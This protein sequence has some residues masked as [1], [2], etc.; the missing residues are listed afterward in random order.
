[1]Y[2]EID[3]K[4]LKLCDTYYSSDSDGFFTDEWIYF[5][6]SILDALDVIFEVRKKAQASDL[7]ELN[8]CLCFRCTSTLAHLYRFFIEFVE[9]CEKPSFMKTI[10]EE[11]EALGKC[12][13]NRVLNALG[14]DCQTEKK[15]AET[16][17]L[18]FNDSASHSLSSTQLK[19]ED[20]GN[21]A[22]E[23]SNFEVKMEHGKTYNS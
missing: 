18:D 21:D 20:T 22:A 14:H 6:V 16:E 17:P 23:T 8:A 12:H 9:S 10:L 1:L 19:T 5:D 3:E 4:A 7:D 13:S 2:E 11:K 15:E